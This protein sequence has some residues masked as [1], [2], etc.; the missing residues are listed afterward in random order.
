MM[1]HSRAKSGFEPRASEGKTGRESPS[2]HDGVPSAEKSDFDV[3][4]GQISRIGSDMAASSGVSSSE[5]LDPTP[6]I[7]LVAASSGVSSSEGLDPTLPISL[8]CRRTSAVQSAQPTPSPPDILLLYWTLVADGT[9]PSGYER[10]FLQLESVIKQAADRTNK[11]YSQEDNV[12]AAVWLHRHQ[13]MDA[14]RAKTTK[15]ARGP[16]CTRSPRPS[17]TLQV[18]VAKPVLR[19]A[20]SQ[21]RRRRESPEEM[22]RCSRRTL[23]GHEDTGR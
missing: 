8:D 18:Q 2:F 11:R 23:E 13:E 17:S 16:T 3:T 21:T 12:S 7:S 22:A 10:E 19:G 4:S 1:S 15:Q 20:G 9:V 6:P 14:K 5:G